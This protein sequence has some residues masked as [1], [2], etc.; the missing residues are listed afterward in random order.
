[1]YRCSGGALLL[2]SALNICAAHTP[3]REQL[4]PLSHQC[5]L[6]LALERS[7]HT[8]TH[9]HTLDPSPLLHPHVNH[10]CHVRV[11]GLSQVDAF[12]PSSCHTCVGGARRCSACR[13]GR[14]EPKTRTHL[15]ESVRKDHFAPALSPLSRSHLLPSVRK[16]RCSESPSA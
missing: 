11:D 3:A 5:C 15:T 9:T 6:D 13:V 16:M 2:P 14:R 4:N 10:E 1:M 7:L 8:H 12:I